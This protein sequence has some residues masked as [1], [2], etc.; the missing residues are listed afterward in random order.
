MNA[1]N[2]YMQYRKDELYHFNPNHSKKDGR[3]ISGRFAKDNV[4]LWN[5][6]FM[7]E[8]GE[9]ELTQPLHAIS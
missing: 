9:Y 8:E 7:I 1:H 6:T 2:R 3:F 4:L 5:M